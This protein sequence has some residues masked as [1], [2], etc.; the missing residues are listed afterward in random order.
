MKF[1]QTFGVAVLPKFGGPKHEISARFR[2]TSR[3]D[4]E[5]LR[6]ATTHRQSENGVANYGHSRSIDPSTGYSSEDWR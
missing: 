6:N 3:L 1:G 5:F 2:T 4:L